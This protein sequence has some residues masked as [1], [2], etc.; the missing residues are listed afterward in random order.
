MF[1]TEGFKQYWHFESK[2]RVQTFVIVELFV[3]VSSL[4]MY[5]VT[6]YLSHLVPVMPTFSRVS[7]SVSESS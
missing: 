3:R 2:A 7:G 4:Y 6:V 1:I 5:A